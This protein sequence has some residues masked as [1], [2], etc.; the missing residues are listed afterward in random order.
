MDGLDWIEPAV[1][2]A[3]V[4]LGAIFV[5]RQWRARRLARAAPAL[6][7][8]VTSVERTDEGGRSPWLVV[9]LYDVPGHGVLRHGRAFD[10][11]GP[12]LLFARLHREGSM[13]WVVPNEVETGQVFLMEELDSRGDWLIPALLAVVACLAAWALYAIAVEYWEP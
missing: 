2:L 8:T 4:V 7:A 11:E 9:T 5:W 3:S 12:A 13:H 1:A 10:K 6:H